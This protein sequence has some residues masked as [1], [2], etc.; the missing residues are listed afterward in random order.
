MGKTVSIHSIVE[1][2]YPLLG[3]SEEIRNIVGDL[4]A[5]FTMLIWGKSGSGKTS[6]TLGVLGK[7]LAANHGKVYYNSKE[8]GEGSAIQNV[9]RNYQVHEVPSGTYM[10][11]DRDSFTEMISKIKRIRAKH[12]IIDSADYLE[13]T[14]GQYK[15]LVDICH[16]GPKRNWKSLIIICWSDDSG[17]NPKSQY[18]KAI[19]YMVDVKVKVHEGCVTADSR[20]GATQPY[21]LWKKPTTG[22]KTL[23]SY[24]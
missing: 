1:N 5:G 6:F 7:Y 4:E 15:K 22:Q 8:Q 3:V 17:D 16:K 24:T 23:F 19:R 11:G 21:W 20:F 9:L 2:E 14:T 13:L 12:I 10:F 18:T